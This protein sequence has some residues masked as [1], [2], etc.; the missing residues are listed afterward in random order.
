M[1]QLKQI[2]LVF[3]EQG[4]YSETDR[5]GTTL[6]EA[7]R[8]KSA[9]SKNLSPKFRFDDFDIILKITSNQKRKNAGQKINYFFIFRLPKTLTVKTHQVFIH[10]SI[11]TRYIGQQI[12]KCFYPVGQGTPPGRHKVAVI[13]LAIRPFFVFGGKCTQVYSHEHRI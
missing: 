12:P 3:G 6:S 7:L 8:R 4:Q 2:N 1:F 9:Q 10:Q 5:R 13:C 11:F